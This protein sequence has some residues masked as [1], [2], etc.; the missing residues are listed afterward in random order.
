MIFSRRC[1]LHDDALDYGAVWCHEFFNTISEK[2][3][4]FRN[5]LFNREDGNNMYMR[6][7]CDRPFAEVRWNKHQITT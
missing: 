5:F 6:R 4:N 2:G 1:K 7:G 3:C